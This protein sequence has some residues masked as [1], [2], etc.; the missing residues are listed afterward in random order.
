MSNRNK[1]SMI[2]IIIFLLSVFTGCSKKAEGPLKKTEM[3]MGTVVSITLYKGG[4][5]STI[6][7]AFNR[8]KEIE[9]T[10]SINKKGTELDKVND[11]A[12]IQPIK[13][14]KDTYEIVEKGLKYSELSEGA[15]DI[16]IGPIVK[17]WSIGL[18][19]AKVPTEEEINNTIP[20]VDYNNVVLN[21]ADESIYLKEK[22]MKI[23]L[24]GIAKG[25]AADE[26][27]K[28][29][30]SD[31]VENAIVDLGGNLYTLG[32]KISGEPW[33][34]GVQN[35]FD[36]RGEIIGIIK[37]TDETIV[38]S[39][40]YERFIEKDGIKYHHILSPTTGYPYDTNIAGVSIV[41]ENSI[42]ADALSTSVFAKGLEEGMEFV[43]KMEGVEAI[44]VTKE[45]KVYVTSGLSSE[46]EITNS[47]F[48]LAQ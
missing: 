5:E 22:G 47:E 4:D 44:F 25:Y 3:F 26:V 38:T 37:A 9:D 32:S 8:I 34:I 2:L 30:K 18:P 15:F 33:N 11:N 1:F 46:F 19:E 6:D 17:L 40:I 28:V 29:L 41:T 10:V 23:D 27:V 13:V 42:D 36:S 7:K 35:P 12:G 45:K 20:L 16:T 21:D 48:K 14:S 39:G 31:G 24:G 43:E